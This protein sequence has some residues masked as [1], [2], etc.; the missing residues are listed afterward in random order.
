MCCGA[1]PGCVLCGRMV[2]EGR[3]S[4][5]LATAALRLGL[6]PKPSPTCHCPLPL[7]TPTDDMILQKIQGKVPAMA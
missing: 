6:L 4:A 7:S 2:A 3:E 5:G 1:G